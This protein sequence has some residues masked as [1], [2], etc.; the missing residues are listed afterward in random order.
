[1]KQAQIV[2]IVD[3]IMQKVAKQ[4]KVKKVK[5][6]AEPKQVRKYKYQSRTEEECCLDVISNKATDVET[7]V[8]YIKC[9][10]RKP[11][12]VADEDGDK[13]KVYCRGRF[14]KAFDDGKI[15][16]YSNGVLR[17]LETNELY[18][19]YRVK[20]FYMKENIYK[21]LTILSPAEPIQKEP[22]Y[23]IKDKKE[24]AEWLENGIQKLEPP[25]EE[26]Y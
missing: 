3:K 16:V 14:H 7:A 4:T 6:K 2:S 5:K 26:R 20:R 15:S 22:N 12:E 13:E 11:F 23:K 18:N 19:I 17:D 24:Y 10:P 21:W 8:Q 25:I 1:M 9:L